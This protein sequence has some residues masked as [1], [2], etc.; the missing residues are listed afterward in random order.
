MEKSKEIQLHMKT[1]KD[2]DKILVGFFFMLVFYNCDFEKA[3]F[4]F[5]L[6]PL[7][8]N[9]G[10][11][12][13]DTLIKSYPY[14]DS[15]LYK[16][17]E[18]KLYYSTG[19]LKEKSTWVRNYLVN[20]CFIYYKNGNIREYRFYNII[21][22]LCYYRQYNED[23]TLKKSIGQ[24]FIY[25]TITNADSI[26]VGDR[27]ITE[28]YI[29]SP[30]NCIHSIYGIYGDFK[31]DEHFKRIRPYIY[32]TTVKFSKEGEYALYFEL[33]FEDTITGIK[34]IYNEEI[35]Y[36]VTEF[37]VQRSVSLR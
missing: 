31:S 10:I 24:P 5:E 33:E 1:I 19:E 26:K 3:E 18:L 11:E 30:P 25:C 34:R 28:I 29:A 6:M 9:S 35:S 4:T 20:E 7:Y 36:S 16:E 27:V 15:T 32:E 23:G 21:G 13:V 17:G 14:Y 12:S 22:E 2:I 8:Y 37:A